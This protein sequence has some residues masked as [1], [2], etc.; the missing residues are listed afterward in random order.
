MVVLGLGSGL[1]ISWCLCVARSEVRTAWESLVL[2]P[3]PT[4]CF[5]RGTRKGK[6]NRTGRNT[7]GFGI[8]SQGGAFVFDQCVGNWF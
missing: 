8:V 4:L 2:R 1:G 6:V 3:T 7:L 5:G